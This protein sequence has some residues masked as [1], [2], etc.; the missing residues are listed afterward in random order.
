MGEDRELLVKNAHQ[1]TL[2][3]RTRIQAAL[4]AGKVVV[5]TKRYGKWVAEFD[6]PQEAHT[7]VLVGK[8]TS[9]QLL[10]PNPLT[11]ATIR[12]SLEE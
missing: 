5:I 8:M 10:Y 4:L 7:A 3:K 9:V 2:C 12:K 11:L 1:C 6:S